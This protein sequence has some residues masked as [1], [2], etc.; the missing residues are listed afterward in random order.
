MG[1]LLTD[2]G[3]VDQDMVTTFPGYTTT[4]VVETTTLVNV[5]INMETGS[6]YGKFLA[7]PT[8]YVH[9]LSYVFRILCFVLY[10]LQFE[11]PPLY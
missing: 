9:Q 3:R 1:A 5:N 11:A 7:V 6:K 4:I 2:N 8:T 10:W